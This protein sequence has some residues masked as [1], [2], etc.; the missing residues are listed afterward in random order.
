VHAQVRAHDL[1]ALAVAAD[2]RPAL[3]EQAARVAGDRV[4]EQPGDAQAAGGAVFEDRELRPGARPVE[5]RGQRD[6]TAPGER[7]AGGGQRAAGGLAELVD[8]QLHGPAAHEPD[9][10]GLLVGDA[11]GDDV[12]RGARQ[13][14][15]RVVHER[16]LDAAAGDRALDAPEV[17]DEHLR[18]RVERRGAE[19]L[20]QRRR[21]DAPS[22]VEPLEGDRL[23][24][25]ERLHAVTLPDVVGWS[26]GAAW[27]HDREQ[28]DLRPAAVWNATGKPS[29]GRFAAASLEQRFGAG[30]G[31]PGYVWAT[32]APAWIPDLIWDPRMASVQGA[33][34]AGLHCA[35]GLPLGAGEAFEGVLEL[36]SDHRREVDADRLGWLAGVSALVAEHLTRSRPR[37]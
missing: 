25:R 2:R 30:R 10:D 33:H 16:A 31:L 11:V 37:G 26:F 34:E 35:V 1:P 36:F 12:R 5:Q 29:V 20:D 19:R 7:V 9:V 27:Q 4:V 14:L 13:H 21:D 6:R 32:G 28:G 8:E 15:A 17:V 22:R 24:P 18:A 3:V 23:R